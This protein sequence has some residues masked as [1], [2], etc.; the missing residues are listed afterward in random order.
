MIRVDKEG[1]RQEIR[2]ANF[3]RGP[4]DRIARIRGIVYDRGAILT[5]RGMVPYP[6]SGTPGTTQGST[7]LQSP[8]ITIS[9]SDLTSQT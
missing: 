5:M 8:D 4:V 9:L 3:L 1:E 2:L 7:I 6:H